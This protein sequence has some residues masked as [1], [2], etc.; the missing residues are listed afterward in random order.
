MLGLGFPWDV[1]FRAGRRGRKKGR[2]GV[3]R[4]AKAGVPRLAKLMA[5]AIRLDGL[6][7]DGVVADQA[8]LSQLGHVTR[9]RVSQIEGRLSQ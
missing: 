9:A 2:D 4:E 3:R 1:H 6:I 7:G 5:L 8:G